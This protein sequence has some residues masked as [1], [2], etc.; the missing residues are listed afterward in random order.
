MSQ[1]KLLI[2][3]QDG[4]LALVLFTGS[5]FFNS[6]LHLKEQLRLNTIPIF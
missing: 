2:S 4:F 1:V 6:L 5:I 3:G